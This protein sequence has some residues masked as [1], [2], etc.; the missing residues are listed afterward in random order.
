MYREKVQLSVKQKI[1]NI[2]CIYA[3]NWYSQLLNLSSKWLFIVG[4]RYCI[5]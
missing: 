2:I 3:I 1:I 5:L 4:L